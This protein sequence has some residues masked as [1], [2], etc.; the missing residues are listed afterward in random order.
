[1]VTVLSCK[2]SVFKAGAGLVP[3]HLVSLR[4]EG[5]WRSG[6]GRSEGAPWP[7]TVRWE[8]SPG[9]VLTVGAAGPDDRA[10]ALLNR[11]IVQRHIIHQRRAEESL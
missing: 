3:V 2:E 8:V 4:L 7:V 11:L 6:W 10:R 9:R 1:M 5:D